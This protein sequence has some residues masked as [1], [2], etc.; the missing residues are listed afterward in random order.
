MNLQ[1][2]SAEL[3]RYRKE[4]DSLRAQL[5]DMSSRR[6]QEATQFES[7]VASAEAEWAQGLA[8]LRLQHSQELEQAHSAAETAKG[9]AAALSSKL[10]AAI[11]ASR[12]SVEEKRV[13]LEEASSL[14]QQLHS[15]SQKLHATEVR[16][17]QAVQVK[18]DDAI[19]RLKAQLQQQS[20][21]AQGAQQQLQLENAELTTKVR[22]AC[23][24]GQDK[25]YCC[26]SAGASLACRA[27]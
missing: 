24:P 21:E 26:V 6:T 8:K 22:Q 2:I 11:S 15:T 16:A 5:S 12:A 3:S 20:T 27:G 19:H 14:R 18:N 13:A 9:N 4:V 7:K 10:D 1:S 25:F 23:E 17:E